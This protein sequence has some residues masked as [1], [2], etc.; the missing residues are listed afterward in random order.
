MADKPVTPCFVCRQALVDYL[1][2]ETKIY[3][4]SLNGLENI[5]TLDQL[6][7]YSFSEENL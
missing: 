2:K 7:P 6:T 4:Y 1:N 3:I 5:Y